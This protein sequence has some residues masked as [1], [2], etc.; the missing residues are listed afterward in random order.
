LSKELRLGRLTIAAFLLCCASVASGFGVI[1]VRG[2]SEPESAQITVRADRGVPATQIHGT[3]LTLRRLS[4]AIDR[5]FGVPTRHFSVR[6]YSSHDRFA[7]ELV[8]TEHLRPQG[9]GDNTANVVRGILRLG[10]TSG[11]DTHRLAHVYTEWILDRLTRNSSDLQPRP[12]W[13]Y[14]GLA[15][16][17]ANRVSGVAVC[18]RTEQISLPLS[19]LVSPSSWWRIRGSPFGPLEYCEAEAQVEK[20]VSHVLWKT[21]L[22]CLR[23]SGSWLR[24]A[25]SVGAAG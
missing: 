4:T 16:Y 21:M 18:R 5:D 6:I 13:L 24:F 23:A 11:G 20:V 9:S 8:A 3:L 17:E 10:P 15:E 12:A 1:Q 25:R 22:E 14:D 2:D 19:R 7:R